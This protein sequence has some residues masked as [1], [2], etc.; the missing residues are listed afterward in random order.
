MR[1]LVERTD[2]ASRNADRAELVGTILGTVLVMPVLA[3]MGYG[4]WWLV[5]LVV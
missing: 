5:H 4:A 1:V 3:G 2:N